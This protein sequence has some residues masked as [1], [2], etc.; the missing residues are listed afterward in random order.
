MYNGIPL[1][2]LSMSLTPLGDALSKTLADSATPVTIVFFR[3]AAAGLM[4]LALARLVSVPVRLPRAELGGTLLQTG[5]VVGAMTL[6]IAALGRVPLATAVGGFLV[7]PIVATLLGVVLLRERLTVAGALGGG[8]SFVGALLILKPAAVPEPGILLAL[9]GGV[10]LGGFLVLARRAR[11]ATQ[12]P[13]AA[14]ALQCLLGAAMLA[15]FTALH[16]GLLVPSLVVPALAL[17]LV[18][19]L[20]HFLTV[21]AY[22]CS[23]PAVLAPFFYFN[24]IVAIAV[25]LVWFGEVPDALTLAGLSGIVLGGLMSLL[26]DG[27]MRRIRPGFTQDG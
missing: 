16:A 5:L 11:G 6:L 27:G 19:A 13:V 7:A 21:A 2:L 20:T 24:L 4:G 9:C 10:M 3:Y 17:G 12:H 8:V 23:A 14:L 22:R 18:T 15:P 26:P 25:G 1:I